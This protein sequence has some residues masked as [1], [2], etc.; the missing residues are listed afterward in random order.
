MIN[1][2]VLLIYFSLCFMLTS[3]STGKLSSF[4]IRPMTVTTRRSKFAR[5]RVGS[6]TLL[7]LER[8]RDP[9]QRYANAQ[10]AYKVFFLFEYNRL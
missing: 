5:A 8:S 1:A 4:A 2:R 7:P 10:D 3:K 6:L 9:D